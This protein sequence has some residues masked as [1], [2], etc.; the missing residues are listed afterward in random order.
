MSTSPSPESV[1]QT[2]RQIRTLVNEISEFSKTDMIATEYY[3]A[4]LQRIIQALAAAGGAIW[5]VDKDGTMKLAY[6]MQL[7]PD[8]MEAENE[9]AIRHARLLTRVIGR[10]QGELIPPMS[11]YGDDQSMANPTRFLLV[12]HP[13]NSG[14]RVE[15]LM[16]IFQRPDSPPDTQKGY[17]K[18]LEHMSKL[19]GEWLKGQ[20]L[21]EV[22]GKQVLWQQ[23]DQFARLVHDNLD[24]RDTAFTI[25]NEGRRLIECDRVSVAILR[26][27]KAKVVSISGQDTIENRS[28]I[29]TSLNDLATRVIRSGEPLWYDGSTEDLPPQ[30]EEAV[31]DYVDLSHGRTITVL[32]IHRPEYTVEGDVHAKQTNQSETRL[33]KEIIGALIIEQIETQMSRQELEGRTDLVYEHACRALTN[34][35]TYND[36]F[37]MP[38]WRNLGRATWFFRGSTLPKTLAVLG[39]VAV[40]LIALFIVRIDFDLEGNGSL[41]PHEQFNVFAHVNGEVEEVFVKHGDNVQ[42]L[43]PEEVQKLGFR[44]W[45]INPNA[46]KPL[47]VMKNRDLDIELEKLEGQKKVVEESLRTIPFQ[48]EKTRLAEDD[49]LRLNR[50]SSELRQQLA[51]LNAQVRA[52]QDKRRQLEKYSPIKGVVTTWKVEETLRQ[53]PVAAGQVLMTIAKTTPDEDTPADKIWE[54]EVKLP[55]KRMKYLD[56]A[57]ADSKEGFLMVDFI[58]MTNPSKTLK[59]KLYRN[60]IESH[61]E[62]DPDDGPV[63]KVIVIPEPDSTNPQD[64]FGDLTK[65]GA[66]LKADIKCGKRSAAF[67]WF[68]EVIE[69]VRAHVLF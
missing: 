30:I 33:S 26:G 16:E 29:V 5:L 52:V 54:V 18:F 15:G 58:L 6:Q 1:E 8:L 22:S 34:S 61:A 41:R 53:R 47:L 32:P 31:E 12:L 11:A 46:P 24:L 45:E 37:L 60:G 62:V 43:A 55:E 49:R 25:A 23:S 67:V 44:E 66:Q 42:S 51:S 64:P 4:V 2:K 7:Q 57:I 68:H 35:L 10:G 59:G 39:L 56:R 9:N 19:M 14:K 38:V 13:L 27:G 48:L 65:P 3:P 36:L 40:A 63:V 28:N 69:W 21:Q 20:S 17:L 50:E